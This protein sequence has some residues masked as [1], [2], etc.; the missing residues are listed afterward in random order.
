MRPAG[1]RLCET[2][3]ARAWRSK[4]S[5]ISRSKGSPSPPLHQRRKRVDQLARFALS[6]RAPRC[7]RRGSFQQPLG[8]VSFWKSKCKASA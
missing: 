7:Q 2:G 4:A 6:V 5:S 1:R 3:V 8:E